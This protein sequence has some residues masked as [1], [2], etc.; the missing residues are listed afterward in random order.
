MYGGGV[1]RK[2]F[3]TKRV[4]VTGGWRKLRNSELYGLYSSPNTI[5]S[6]KP[7]RVRWARHVARMGWRRKMRRVL[8]GKP[9]G[10]RP[11]GRPRLR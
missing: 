3:G 11:L 2:I 10:K 4:A 9:E 5:R 8:V 7:M 1:L 6:I